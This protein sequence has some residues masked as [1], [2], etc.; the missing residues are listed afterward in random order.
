MNRATEPL[1]RDLLL[2]LYGFAIDEYRFE[3]RL[4][5]DRTR[6]YL[7][8][9][10]ALLTIATGLL[11]VENGRA[12]DALVMLL[13]TGGAVVSIL[14]AKA[15]K[16]GHEYYRRTIF[17]KTLIEEQLGLLHRVGDSDHPD[18]TLTI[19]TTAGMAN[20]ERILQDPGSW[21]SSPLRRGSISLFLMNFLRFLSVVN[22][23][24]FVAAL[25][26]LARATPFVRNNI[27]ALIP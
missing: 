26:R 9:N 22:A 25:I 8:L 14:A 1:H 16:T 11:R 19:G 15:V 6:D 3:V 23:C 27:G 13:F 17:K 20:I 18:A 12:V 4:S 10:L 21:I 24:G 5:S 7:V 2:K